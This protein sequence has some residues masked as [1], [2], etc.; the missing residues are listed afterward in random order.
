MTLRDFIECNK[1]YEVEVWDENVDI[2]CP[3]YFYG[4]NS[5]KDDDDEHNLY[6]LENWFL[7]L[8]V[9]H[10]NVSPFEISCCVDVYSI[11]EKN[12]ETLSMFYNSEDEEGMCDCTQDVF[13][14]L[15]QGVYGFA[16]MFVKAMGLEGNNDKDRKNC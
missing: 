15:S 3:Y 6:V 4:E 13:T 2:D 11:I 9:T 1:Q 16:R 8:E 5:Y 12:W 14:A 7:G 10:S